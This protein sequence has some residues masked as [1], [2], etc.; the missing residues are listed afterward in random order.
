MERGV[1]GAAR[2]ITMLPVAFLMVSHFSTIL[3]DRVEYQVQRTEEKRECNAAIG[4][5]EIL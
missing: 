4:Y 5:D 1:A 2:R 3:V